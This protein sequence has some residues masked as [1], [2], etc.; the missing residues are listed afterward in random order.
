MRRFLFNQAGDI[1]FYLTG[2]GVIY[3]VL[4]EP[5]GIV[6]RG[7]SQ[8]DAE[9]E[10]VTGI[11]GELVA[12]FD[13]NFLWNYDGELLAFLKGAKPEVDFELPETQKLAFAPQPKAAPFKPLLT[14][15]KPPERVWR[16]SVHKLASGKQEFYT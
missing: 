15:A 7:M 13:D 14:R 3:N 6:Q 12:W 16:W 9:L 11:N 5:V 4:N 2:A 10:P 1:E 8:L